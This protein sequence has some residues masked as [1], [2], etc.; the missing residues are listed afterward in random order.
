[1]SA[2]IQ[3]PGG[4]SPNASVLPSLSIYVFLCVSLSLP[5]LIPQPETVGCFIGRKETLGIGLYQCR[6]S[7]HRHDGFFSFFLVFIQDLVWEGDRTCEDYQV[8]GTVLG[9]RH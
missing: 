4:K 9:A 1:M 3:S 7:I 5:H 2:L 8:D 6:I